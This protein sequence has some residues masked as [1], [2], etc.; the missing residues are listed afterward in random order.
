M[1]KFRD[2]TMICPSCHQ[3][4]TYRQWDSINADL[5]PELRKEILSGKIY[6]WNCPHCGRL[7][8]VL[9]PTLYHDMK[10]KFMIYF[11]PR[12][13][14]EGD[15]FTLPPDKKYIKFFKDYTY[16]SA[17]D[18]NDFREKIIQLE[19]GLDDRIIELMKDVACYDNPPEGFPEDTEYRFCCVLPEEGEPE[20]ILFECYFPKLSDNAFMPVPYEFYQ[21]LEKEPMTNKIFEQMADFPEVSHSFLLEILKRKT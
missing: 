5:D 7:Y 8:K 6:N 11:D 13:P 21:N 20:K 16:R 18:F 17:F 10:R 2:Q 3:P 12:R 14:K 9:S 19:S 4:A 15:G 1:S